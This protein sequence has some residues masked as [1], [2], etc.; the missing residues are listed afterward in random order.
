MNLK[1]NLSPSFLFKINPNIDWSFATDYTGEQ[2]GIDSGYGSV[3]NYM[4]NE[5]VS[6]IISV[7]ISISFDKYAMIYT[8]PFVGKSYWAMSEP[9]NISNIPMSGSDMDFLNPRNAFFQLPVKIFLKFI[10][11]TP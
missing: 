1:L 8:E 10:K 11:L 4:E 7:P 2:N 3:S 5:F 9:D 6:P